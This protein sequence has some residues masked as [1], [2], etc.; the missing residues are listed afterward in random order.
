[1]DNVARISVETHTDKDGRAV[2]WLIFDNP[3]RKNALNERMWN[4]LPK[5]VKSA[6][7]DPA[8][9]AVVLAGAGSAA[10]SAGA[11]I[12]EFE[13]MTPLEQHERH[14]DFINSGF[15][16][17]LACPKPTIAMI[18]GICF[19]GGF[20]LAVCCDFRLASERSRFSIPAAKLGV[21]YN[22]R[23]I[24]PLVN[25]V[26]PA[27]AKEILMTGRVYDAIA[28]E[29]MGLLT[30][31]VSPDALRER[32]EALLSDLLANAPL[33]MT[34]AKF[35]VDTL[36]HPVAPVEMCPLDQAVTDCFTSEDYLEGRRAFM[37]KRAPKFRGE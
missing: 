26:G 9:R 13:A 27:K 12:S 34:A 14:K 4:E 7:V 36:S 3:A 16:A 2:R 28:A 18:D 31:L 29:R 5:L 1:M 10:F 20:E 24:K 17:L 22:A 8:V 32:T 21:G 30:E 15:G 19:G 37:E 23:W 6:A 35:C 33:T 25:V 11:D